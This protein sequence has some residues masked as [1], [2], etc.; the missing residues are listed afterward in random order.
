MRPEDHF[1]F[2]AARQQLQPEHVRR[3][4]ELSAAPGFDWQGVFATAE[5]FKVA[6]LV[7][8][9]IAGLPD[10]AARVPAALIEQQR[11]ETMLSALYTQERAKLLK[12]AMCYLHERGIDAIVFKGAAQEL[13][14]YDHPWYATA[15][16]ID[17]IL[18]P[19]KE[20]LAPEL[21]AEIGHAFHHKR[22]EF[23]FY[24]HHDMTING[25]LPVDFEV[26]WRDARPVDCY[27]E[28][29]LTLSPEDHLIA[30][31]INSCRKR[32]FRL[33][34]LFDIHETILKFQEL[35]WQR[36]CARARIFG[37]G[38]IVY[39]ALLVTVRTL[40][41][42]LPGGVLPQLG[43]SAARKA[44]VRAGVNILLRYGRLVAG[45]SSS[46][47]FKRRVDPLLLL[48]YLTYTPK[49]ILRKF[50]EVRAANMGE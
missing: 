42:P 48:P 20:A 27:G 36:F 18:R 2:L 38:N 12:M 49:Q 10:L 45:S 30:L 5:Y 14:V 44:A 34:S 3:M 1:L 9:H 33:K 23:D 22:I 39:A 47:I 16:D 6:P 15:F 46:M 50:H 35:D 8:N 24:D 21:V 4:G 31:C 37:C 11:R 25:M 7:Y 43:V 32:F 41:T 26:V 28:P 13:L 40:G 29:G 19:R 17:L